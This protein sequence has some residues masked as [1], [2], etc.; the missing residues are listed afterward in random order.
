MTAFWLGTCGPSLGPALGLSLQVL[1]WQ[2][3]GPGTTV[4][5]AQASVLLPGIPDQAFIPLDC[6]KKGTG[7]A[8]LR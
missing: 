2:H 8:G 6:E 1:R 5:Q 4:C 3:P 7:Y